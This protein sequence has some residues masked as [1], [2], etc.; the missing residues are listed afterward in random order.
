MEV[1]KF[2]LVIN[3]VV[4]AVL[5]ISTGTAKAENGFLGNFNNLYGTADS[6]LDSCTTC[7]TGGSSRNSYG[8]D[9]QSELDKGFGLNTAIRNVEGTD[10]DGD[11]FVNIDEIN[12]LTFPGNPGDFPE[13]PTPTCTDLDGDG[14]G[15]PGDPSC[16]NGG[17]TDCND[18]DGN[19]N[20]A[21]I[22]DCTNGI[23]DDCDNFVDAQDPDAVGCPP[24]CT[25]VDGDTF[26][27]EGG[28]NC[29]PVDCDDTVFAVNPGATENCLNTIDDDCDGFVDGDDPDCGG[30]VATARH[31]KGKKC[32]DGIDNDCNGVADGD[33]PSCQRGKVNGP[34]EVCDDSID[35]DLDGK[36]DCADKKDCGKDPSCM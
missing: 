25:D 28:S 20:P 21:A 31:E 30:C 16:P 11:N 4:L 7:H 23:D 35:N 26:A 33:D 18:N 36:I 27:V 17:A 1:K 2:P 10:S 34:P 6:R 3:L 12:A 5:F 24:I 15:N 19:V 14:F 13:D 9:I 29:G 8:S 22:E 32:S